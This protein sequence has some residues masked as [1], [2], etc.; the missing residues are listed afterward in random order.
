MATLVSVCV[1]AGSQAAGARP[2]R[3]PAQAGRP[4]I[5]VI[6]T[7]DQRFDSLAQMPN[8][9]HL[10]AAHGVTFTNAFVTTSECCPSRASIL[11]GE[12]SHDTGVVQ[13]FGPAGYPR[14]DQTLEPRRVAPRT[15]ATTPA[16]VGK[17]LNDYTVYGDHRIPPGWS[18]WRGDRLAAGGAVLR[19]H[20][21]RER[22]ARPLR[23]GAV[24][25]LDRRARRGRRSASSGTR[26]GR[27]SSTS[28]RSRR[29][30]RRSRH[31]RDLDD[32]GRAPEAAA[33]LRR[34][35]HRRQAVA[36][37]LPPR[38]RRR[39]DRSSSTATSR[40][41][42]SAR[43]ASVDR[44]VGR[45]STR[46]KQARRAAQHDRDLHE[47]QRLHLGRAPARREA[48]AVRGVDPRAARRPRPVAARRGAS[49]ATSRS[50][51]TSPRRS[52]SSRA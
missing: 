34:A 48:L 13:N 20:A 41:A 35:R 51:S 6:L 10:L 49:T 50:T 23:D 38:A 7:D 26:A 1:L 16:L 12:Y 36:P 45:S 18:D 5:V 11:S 17:Y 42:S 46:S 22:P 31:Q 28:R 39:R 3:R 14:F 43:S 19:L 15:R 29:T 33:G 24:G 9:E 25:L 52:R 27:S 30:C 47:R 40:A 8:V 2:E 32:A 21:E 4:N 37:A 44:Q